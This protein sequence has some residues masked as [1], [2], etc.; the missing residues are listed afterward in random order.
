MPSLLPLQSLPRQSSV[1]SEAPTRHSGVVASW[2]GAEQL[3]I[4][5]RDDLASRVGGQGWACKLAIAG[6]LVRCTTNAWAEGRGTRHIRRGTGTSCA[7]ASRPAGDGLPTPA[8]CNVFHCLPQ[9]AKKD[10]LKVD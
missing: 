4:A 1:F 5:A 2:L 8:F 10:M 3:V 9:D 7:A 6:L